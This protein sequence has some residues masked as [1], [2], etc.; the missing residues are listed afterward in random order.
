MTNFAF[1]ETNYDINYSGDETSELLFYDIPDT[2]LSL[3]DRLERT[4]RQAGNTS[5][6]AC[7]GIVNT[8]GGAVLRAVH[9]ITFG[10]VFRT[11]ESDKPLEIKADPEPP[12]KQEW[13]IAMYIATDFGNECT[14]EKRTKKL[15]ELAEGTKDKPVTIVVQT[16]V[17]NKDGGYDLERFALKNGSII[18]LESPGKTK[19][20]AQDV[21]DLLK[22]TT[23]K[24]ESKNICLT[25]D[26]HGTGNGG[27]H[28]D[29]G[30]MSLASLTKAVKNGLKGTVHE[31]LDLLQ[32]DA[33]LM[34]QNGVL[35]STCDIT[36][37]IVASAEPEGTGAGALTADNRQLTELLKK[38]KM[39]AS[40]LADTF[41][42]QSNDNPDFK[43]L[44]HFDLE[45]YSKFRKSLD[46]FGEKLTKLC[47]NEDNLK[48]IRKILS[49]TFTYGK[50]NFMP[51]PAAPGGNGSEH[52]N[53]W[54]MRRIQ[55]LLGGASF[56][57]DKD[58][59]PLIN[60]PAS[61]VVLPQLPTLEPRPSSQ[62]QPL[63]QPE[64]SQLESDGI[65]GIFNRLWGERHKRD[66]KDFVARVL[67]AIDKG[68]LTDEDGS[69]RQAAKDVLIDGTALTKSFYGRD[70][71]K[72]LG[73]LSAFLP[74]EASNGGTSDPVLSTEGGWR[75]FQKILR[76]SGAKKKK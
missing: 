14:I 18:K 50:P 51:K 41:V 35:E 64:L 11:R 45:K 9:D 67:L 68:H 28:G 61:G 36:K 10:P 23:T 47:A 7:A 66:L 74:S 62:L 76:E 3:L 58:A 69:L 4:V 43:T 16:A 15:Q 57:S 27:L 33:C 17:K 52:D 38:P 46:T 34:A 31:K 8:A 73:G 1:E 75:Q 54:W 26:S 70:E 39:T 13:T 6:G 20:Y 25:L 30:D 60:R 65:A 5:A 24:Y 42:A 22:F 12:V 63:S 2:T 19:G 72:T 48:V 56:P 71:R 44:A 37:H 59:P 32:F 53:S 29:V 55:S 21:E 49:E 40:E